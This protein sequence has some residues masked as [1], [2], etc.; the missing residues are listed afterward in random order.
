MDDHAEIET[1]SQFSEQSTTPS[2]LP[3]PVV[4]I[5]P[6]PLPTKTGTNAALFT[7]LACHVAFYTAEHQREHHRSDWHRYN[8]KRKVAE[9]PPI[10]QQ[11]FVQ[12][13]KAQQAAE[14]AAN[15]A[16]PVQ[17]VCV[18][19]GKTYNNHQTYSTHL[20]S[21]RHL[22]AIEAHRGTSAVPA[23]DSPL[24]TDPSDTASEP[25]STNWRLLLSQATT[26]A[27]FSRLWDLKLAASPRLTPLHCL[28]CP[29]TSDTLD[30]NLH[31]MATQHGFRIP[32]AEFVVDV[33]GL[34]EFLGVKVAVANLCLVCNGRGKAM[35][36][37]EA[38]RDHMVAKGHC[39]VGGEEEEWEELAP[40]YDFSAAYEEDAEEEDGEDLDGEDNVEGK[41]KVEEGE[42]DD[43]SSS[44]TDSLAPRPKPSSLPSTPTH[45]LPS[46]RRIQSRSSHPHNTYHSRRQLGHVRPTALTPA[47][48]R[49]FPA[50]SP[51][52]GPN[53]LVRVADRYKAMGVGLVHTQRG[54]WALQKGALKEEVKGLRRARDVEARVGVRNN[55]SG[56]RKYFYDPNSKGG[57]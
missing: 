50:P 18:P 51:M 17:L 27:E 48:R 6:G 7:C 13:L 11:V 2:L 22:A 30:A 46:G 37:L 43:A 5:P 56:L 24:T 45:T 32:D 35:H 36:S 38:V 15:N 4:A 8:M 49:A 34:L 1:A 9:L 25:P 33:E 57:F 52:G 26:D 23:K 42:D 55:K 54:L 3:P 31:H 39:K 16:G 20:S 28:F 21:R 29:S 14:L 41:D 12:R 53:A 44:W 40:F 10:S 19:C 47:P